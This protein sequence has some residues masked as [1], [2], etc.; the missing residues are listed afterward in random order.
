MKNLV[1]FESF[2]KLD[3]GKQLS[4]FPVSKNGA[5]VGDRLEV[6][7]PVSVGGELGIKKGRD[8]VTLKITKPWSVKIEIES[9][10]R[11]FIEGNSLEDNEH[12]KKGSMLR[13]PSSIVKLD[14]TNWKKN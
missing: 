1:N 4:I 10:G 7:I 12:C 13:M 8:W 5:N 2:V 9:V 14:T 6:H 3:E 11:K